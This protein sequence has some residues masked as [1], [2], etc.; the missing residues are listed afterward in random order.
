MK[1]PLLNKTDL[2]EFE[3]IQS[4]HIEPAIEFILQENRKKIKDLITEIKEPTWENFVEPI[5]ELD[6]QL[7]RAW[8][9][10]SHMNSVVNSDDTR[11]AYNACLQKISKYITEFSQNEDLYKLYKKLFHSGKNLNT[12]QTR[13]LKLILDDFYLSGIDLPDDKKKLFKKN[14]QLLSEL[15]SKFSENVLDCSNEW[16]KKITDL[17]DLEGLPQSIVDLAK[18]N[19]QEKNE[20]GWIITLDQP[21]YIPIMQYSDNRKLREELYIAY[22]TRASNDGPHDRKFDNSQIME[23]ILK[24]RHEQAQL[25]GFNNFAELSLAK[26]MASS[27]EEVL[28][29]LLQLTQKSKLQAERELLELRNFAKTL[30]LESIEAWDFAYLSEKLK[31]ERYK[32]S[33]EEIRPFFPEDKVVLGMFHIMSKV[34]QVEFE[35]VDKVQKWHQDVKFFSIK[36]ENGELIAQ[37]YLD[38]YA[39]AKKQGGAWMDTFVGRRVTTKVNQ[40]PVAY[41]T[42]NFSPPVGKNNALLNHDEVETLFH[43]FGHGLHHMLTKINYPS[44]AGINGVAWDAVE[45]PSQFME[46]FCWNPEALKI[47]SNHYLENKPIP[48]EMIKKME[49]AKNFQSAIAMLRQIEFSLFDFLIHKEFD[50]KMGGRIYEILDQVREQTAVIFPPEI[51]RFAHSFS[52][53]FSGGYA[54]GYYSYKWAEVLSADAFSLFEEKGIFDT[55]TGKLFLENILE[56]GGSSDAA[57]LFKNFRGRN[58][59]IEP[60]LRYSGISQ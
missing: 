10:V 46:N 3:N 35:S 32:I 52:H 45:L 18:Q 31:K 2:P 44:I 17:K 60:L 20:D 47:I 19:A 51:N 22:N 23:Q 58:P 40:L 42:C 57:D 27:A 14:R 9:P 26:K 13:V 48:N 38:L 33:S 49:R 53:I 1:N 43:E 59:I 16:S 55:D 8:S 21:L 28:D 4:S 41:I 15:S 12:H 50:P 6:E 30:G 34:F 11:S 36:N 54:A 5:D 56:M 7:T 25:L 29:F 24:L 37:F 39:R